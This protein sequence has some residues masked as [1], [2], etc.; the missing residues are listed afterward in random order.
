MT[1][2]ANATTI[3]MIFLVTY[4]KKE[5]AAHSTRMPETSQGIPIENGISWILAL[6]E[7]LRNKKVSV[8]AIFFIVF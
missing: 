2:L 8:T 5:N 3:V 6:S 1:Y 4:D 7:L